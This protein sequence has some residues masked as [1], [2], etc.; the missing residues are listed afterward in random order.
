MKEQIRRAD[1]DQTAIK[2][3]ENGNTVGNCYGNSDDQA[4]CLAARYL[5]RHLRTGFQCPWLSTGRVLCRNGIWM[6]TGFAAGAS[7]GRYDTCYKMLR[8][9][10]ICGRKVITKIFN[11]LNILHK[12]NKK[13]I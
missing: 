1:S 12:N 10:P 11:L 5:R 7:A 4:C 13:K 9:E 8:I 3:E 2:E 6:C